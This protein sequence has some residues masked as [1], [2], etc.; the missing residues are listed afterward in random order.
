MEWLPCQHT[1][2]TKGEKGR[3]VVCKQE[4]KSIW[5]SNCSLGHLSQ[6][7]ENLHSHKTCAQ[8]FH[9]SFPHNSPKLEITQ[10]YFNRQMVKQTVVHPYHGILLSNKRNRLLTHT[11]TWIELQEIM[12]SEKNQ[13]LNIADCII[14]LT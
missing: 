12:P 14:P 4:I 2:T 3:N 7:N 1:T 5:S 13:F 10:M 11:V 9:C 6:R 8:M